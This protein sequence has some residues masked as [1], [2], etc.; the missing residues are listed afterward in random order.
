[1]LRDSAVVLHLPVFTVDAKNMQRHLRWQPRPWLLALTLL[2]LVPAMAIWTAALAS[3]LGI[4]TLITALPTPATMTTRFERLVVLD[5]VL[6]VMLVLPALAVLASVLATV[7][8]ELRIA[9]WEITARL[10]LPAPPWRSTQVAALLLIVVGALLFLAMAG[11]LAAD[12]LFG[13]DCVPG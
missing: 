5:T 12:C 2:A 8:V 4:A 10:R 7:A 11:H 13:T 9:G 6:A 3:S 1:M